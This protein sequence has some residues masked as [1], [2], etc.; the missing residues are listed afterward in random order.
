MHFVIYLQTFLTQLLFND[1]QAEQTETVATEML[2]NE[3][4]I[5]IPQGSIPSIADVKVENST[6]IEETPEHEN[7]ANNTDAEDKE[8]IAKPSTDEHDGAN[9]VTIN[10]EVS[11]NFPLNTV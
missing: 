9:D 6:E 7:A 2:M 1:F 5:H 3:Q 4:T 8:N 11:P 10:E